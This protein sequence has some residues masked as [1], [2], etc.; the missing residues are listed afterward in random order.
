[1]HMTSAAVFAGTD[2]RSRIL[3]AA[4]HLLR[5]RGYHASGLTDILE[6]AQAPKGSMYHH[7]PGGKEE[8]GVA[9][10]EIIIH[11]L[12]AI[13]S[14]PKQ[15]S[16]AMV[17]KVAGKELLAV[18]ARTKFEICAMLSSFVAEAQ[19]SPK[20]ALAVSQAYARMLDALKL[21]LMQDGMGKSDAED[22]AKIV[23]ALLEGGSLLSQTQ[24]DIRALRLAIDQAVK[25]CA[26]PRDRA[27]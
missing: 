2:T 18:A 4:Y 22:L 21:R 10:V 14:A 12:L 24:Q 11:D 5:K 19:S 17:L 26:Q 1:M 15:S 27:K 20:L 3:Q 6:L 16:T 7:F 9:V 23:I 25:L 8:L 13:F